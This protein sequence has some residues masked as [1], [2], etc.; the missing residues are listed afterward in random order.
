MA[1]ALVALP[2]TWY[3]EDRIA[4]RQEAQTEQLASAA[5]AQE[6]LRFARELSTQRG[7]AKPMNGIDLRAANLSGLQLG[8]ETRRAPLD[9]AYPCRGEYPAPDAAHMIRANLAGA[10]LT[11]TDLTGAVLAQADLS[12][13][14]LVST[15]LAGANLDDARLVDANLS[16]SGDINLEAL[17]A[18]GV[19]GATLNGATLVSADLSGANLSYASVVAVVLINAKLTNANL[20]EAILSRADLRGADLTGATLTGAELDSICFDE[21]TRWPQGFPRPTDPDGCGR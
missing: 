16:A 13:T 11:A 4:D 5:E 14:R 10:D 1:F 19:V 15:G 21:R 2:A 20:T 12:G 7:G 17:G 18:T 9:A 3:L 6:N 8:C